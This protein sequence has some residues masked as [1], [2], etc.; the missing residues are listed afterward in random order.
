MQR[1]TARRAL[2][3]PAMACIWLAAPA[4]AQQQPQ[5]QQPQ[6]EQPLYKLPMRGAPASRIGGGT[7]GPNVDTPTVTVFAP[8]HTGM[9]VNPQPTLYWSLSKQAPVQIELTLLDDAGIKPLIEKVLTTPLPGGIHA[10]SLKDAGVTLTPGIDYRWHVALV[11][12]PKMR[13]SDVTSSGTIRLVPAP[14][15]LKA[16][17][18]GERAAPAAYAA[19]GLWYDSIDSLMR[20]ID[21]SPEDAQ[22]KAQL[23]SLLTQ[24]GITRVAGRH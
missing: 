8:D 10:L 18:S 5:S 6:A 20:L 17:L 3:G 14:D 13:S 9:T 7:R 23:D 16:R 19:E 15:T 2:L 12:D 1:W 21:A 11:F 4:Q 22:L 24:V